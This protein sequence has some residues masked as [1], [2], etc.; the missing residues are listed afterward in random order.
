MLCGVDFGEWAC[1]FVVE[2]E[3]LVLVYVV[4]VVVVVERVLALQNEGEC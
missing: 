1:V 4:V 2:I 3:T